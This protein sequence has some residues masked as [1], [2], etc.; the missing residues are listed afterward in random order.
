ML[1]MNVGQYPAFP[2]PHYFSDLLASDHPSHSEASRIRFQG[3]EECL[4]LILS[5]SW[6]KNGRQIH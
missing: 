6:S 1:K 5:R 3:G 4:R 2:S